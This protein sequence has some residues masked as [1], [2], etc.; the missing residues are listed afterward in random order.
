MFPYS[1]FRFINESYIF[2]NGAE[3]R[4]FCSFNNK[5]IVL[6]TFLNMFTKGVH[7]SPIYH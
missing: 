1:R 4:L 6:F 3:C 2:S 7:E 5:P